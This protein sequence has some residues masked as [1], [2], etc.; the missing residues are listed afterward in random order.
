[1]SLADDLSSMYQHTA[2]AYGAIE[3]GGGGVYWG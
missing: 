3:A 2:E 1:M